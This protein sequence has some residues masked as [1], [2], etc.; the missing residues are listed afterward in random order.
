MLGEDQE[1]TRAEAWSDPRCLA[2][3]AMLYCCHSRQAGSLNVREITSTAN[4]I[5]K[6]RGE[7]A[8]LNAKGLG[9]LVRRLGFKP[10]RDSTGFAIRLDDMIR[11]KIHQLARAF[12]VATVQD[13]AV[14]CADCVEIALSLT[15]KEV[16]AAS[17]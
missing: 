2:I 7:T 12:D 8:L 10:R 9:V 15:N 1:A 11:R 14:M 4:A 13:G 17:T 5:M 16:E 6:G 3:E